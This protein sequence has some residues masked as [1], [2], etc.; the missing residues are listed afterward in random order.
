MQK[1]AKRLQPPLTGWEEQSADASP[2]YEIRRRIMA[3]SAISAK[4]G[5]KVHTRIL[6]K[7]ILRIR[8]CMNCPW[9]AFTDDGE[10]F[11]SDAEGILSEA[12]GGSIGRM[13]ALIGTSEFQKKRDEHI[14]FESVVECLHTARSLHEIA[15]IIEQGYTALVDQ[16]KAYVDHVCV[17]RYM[18]K[19]AD[20]AAKLNAA[21]ATK[22][23]VE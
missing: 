15:D 1:W 2:S 14:H 17:Q 3:N 6:F 18:S 12:E 9:C 8:M 19:G 10:E 21:E 22:E 5:F 13:L 23:S 16:Y 20:A 11:C 4:D 7:Y